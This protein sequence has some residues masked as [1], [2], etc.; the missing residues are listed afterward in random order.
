VRTAKPL[1]HAYLDADQIGVEDAEDLIGR[2][3]RVGQ[4]PE[5]VEQGTHAQFAPYRR[6]MLHGAVMIG[7]KHEADAHF[8]DA[9]PDL[10]RRQV[11]IHAEGFE[12]VGAARLRRDRTA[13]MFGDACASRRGD[14]HRGGRD[15]EGLRTVATRAASVYQAGAVADQHLGRQLAHDL[16]GGRD[17]ADRLLLHA[18]ADNDR[19]D[20]DRR[21][22]A[23]HDLT[24]QGDHFIV[25]NLAVFDDP[26]QGV[27][28]LH[29]ACSS[30]KF[31]NR[32]WPLSLRIDS[33]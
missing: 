8:I 23:A 12:Y 18:Q 32:S 29:L 21:H 17:F 11:D 1:Q 10:R 27:L 14:E 2:V 4:R 7:G 9:R 6:R 31:C 33:G 30:R 5:D 28:G 20:H 26:C 13:T 3:G 16:R 15:V 19:G 22:F 24:H 25:K